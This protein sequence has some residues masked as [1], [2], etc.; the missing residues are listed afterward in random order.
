MAQRLV[1][2]ARETGMVSV[3]IT[4]PVTHCMKLARQLQDKFSLSLCRIV[5]SVGLENDAIQQMLAVEGS[6]VMAQFI[7][8]EKPRV[9]GVGSGKRC[10]PLL[11]LCL[12]TIARNINVYH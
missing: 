1:S 9:F 6:E 4:H 12:I 3:G 5:P 8:D 7:G 2:G 10:A 11:M